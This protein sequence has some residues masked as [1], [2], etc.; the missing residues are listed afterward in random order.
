MQHL[1]YSNRQEV[2]DWNAASV[3]MR[4]NAAADL[5]PTCF[6]KREAVRAAK[7]ALVMSGQPLLLGVSSQRGNE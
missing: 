6:V 2:P 3:S 5:I 1:P 7:T 4:F